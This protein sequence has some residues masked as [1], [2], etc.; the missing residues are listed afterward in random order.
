MTSTSTSTSS[1]CDVLVA[2][3]LVVLMFALVGWLGPGAG[4]W[5]SSGG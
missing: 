3:I 1:G 4:G 2:M 5:Y